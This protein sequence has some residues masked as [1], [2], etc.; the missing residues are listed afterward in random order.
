MVVSMPEPLTR[1]IATGLVVAFAVLALFG[2]VASE[3]ADDLVR[4]SVRVEHAYRVHRHLDAV[5]QGLN[6]A[7][8]GQR[9]DL[10]TGT[11]PYP[12]GSRDRRRNVTL[13]L[14][15]LRQLS[16]GQPGQT[17]RL[18]A[19]DSLAHA[20]FDELDQAVAFRRAAS[21]HAAVAAVGTDRGQRAADAVRR[22]IE[23]LRADEDA[24]LAASSRA[25]AAAALDAQRALVLLVSL[26]LGVGSVAGRSL[27]R[28]LRE[29]ARL[30]AELS[31]ERER[32]A[33]VLAQL[34]AGVVVA[35]APTGRL[36]FGNA[37]LEEIWGQSFTALSNPRDLGGWLGLAAGWPP[38]APFGSPLERALADGQT[39]AGAELPLARADGTAGVQRVHAGP[40][41]DTA[42]R[43]IAG[44]ALVE[45]VT[46]ARAADA[47]RARATARLA[48]LQRATETL[49]SALSVG[50]IGDVVVTRVTQ[51]LGADAGA[52]AVVDAD[53]GDVRIAQSVGYPD[54][55]TAAWEHRAPLANVGIPLTDATRLATPVYLRSRSDWDT[56]YPDLAAAHGAHG[57]EGAA[58]LPCIADGRVLG[59]IALSFRGPCDLAGDDATLAATLAAQCAQA[60]YR[61]QLLQGQR[62]ARADAE[63]S[64]RAADASAHSIAQLQRLTERVST[65]LAP[66]D[67]VRVVGEDVAGLVGARGATLFMLPPDNA[68]LE[69]VATWPADD[70]DGAGIRPAL[71]DLATAALGADAVLATE[72]AEVTGV[73]LPLRAG[74]GAIGVLALELRPARPLG[75]EER[76]LLAAAGR[77]AAQ[78]ITRARLQTLRED[79]RR[80]LA[81]ELHDEFGQALTGL[82]LDLAWL[83]RRLDTAAPALAP[84]VAAMSGR[85][86]ATVDAVRRIAAEL[87]PAVLDDLGLGAALEWQATEFERRSGVACTLDTPLDDAAVDEP[88]ATAV[89]RVF[90]EALTNVARHAGARRVVARLTREDDTL[91]LRVADD[92]VGV[93][94]GAGRPGA[95]G[96]VG[97][98]ERAAA[99]GGDV[100][101]RPGAAGG[102]VVTLRVPR[103]RPDTTSDMRAR[104]DDVVRVSL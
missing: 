27:F 57:Y 45:D 18:A 16:A 21:R 20:E 17:V 28:D 7:E 77:I 23:T 10:L 47:A 74:R 4:S 94:P 8:I 79:D 87:R 43:V 15:A 61:V 80:R 35:D 49:G 65:A 102:T 29:R 81:R 31:A 59:A 78:G 76:E 98:R 51:V 86:D 103:A 42:G 62:R 67:V 14:A 50:A 83:G 69:S 30:G 88:T 36:V 37:R 25:Q 52:L 89:F 90:Q 3:T 24:R 96:L 40:V 34:P 95:V 75:A 82:K 85:V 53:T 19:L 46:D 33:A 38:A 44:V 101:V 6:E 100:T 11:D 32:L 55:V 63:A 93:A 84:D 92:G 1:R 91:V 104:A 97:M 56:R 68:T 39:T 48:D 54:E 70:L 64:A 5:L 66:A 26:T 99:L 41:R 71:A 60:L 13:A 22:T 12:R 9:A 2:V 72:T 73:A 58:V